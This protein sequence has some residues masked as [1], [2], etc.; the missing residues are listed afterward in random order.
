MTE[1]GA[2]EQEKPGTSHSFVFTT[3][4]VHYK[5][6]QL[7]AGWC[8]MAWLWCRGSFGCFSSA[9]L[10]ICSVSMPDNTLRANTLRNVLV[11]FAI[12]V[13]PH[14]KHFGILIC[15]YLISFIVSLSYMKVRDWQDQ[16]KGWERKKRRVVVKPKMAACSSKGGETETLYIGEPFSCYAVSPVS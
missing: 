12:L 7:W 15:H 11:D 4:A 10:L 9:M 6:E 13:S 8:R 1:Q 2:Y 5:T 16:G 3:A 14:R